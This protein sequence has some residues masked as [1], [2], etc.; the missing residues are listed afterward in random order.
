MSDLETLE[1]LTRDYIGSVQGCDVRRFDE[2]LAA[3][4]YCSNLRASSRAV[5]C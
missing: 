5:G 3:E 4:F 1:A 2:I